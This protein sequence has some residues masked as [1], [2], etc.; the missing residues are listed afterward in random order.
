M[1]TQ[2]KIADQFDDYNFL[3]PQAFDRIVFAAAM[4]DSIIFL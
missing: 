2:L 3:N 1:Q 4:I